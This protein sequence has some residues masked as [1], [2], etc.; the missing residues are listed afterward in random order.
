MMLFLN[1]TKENNKT[2]MSLSEVSDI[3]CMSFPW[4]DYLLYRYD[5]HLFWLNKRIPFL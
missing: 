2:F 5:W 1:C 3:H 4:E